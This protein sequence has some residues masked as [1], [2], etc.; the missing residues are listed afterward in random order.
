MVPTGSQSV[1]VSNLNEIISLLRSCRDRRQPVVT[2]DSPV[3]RTYNLSR[4][5]GALQ[6]DFSAISHCLIDPAKKLAVAGPGTKYSTI[7]QEAQSKGM[8]IDIE[9]IAC[10]DF[11][12]GD[13]AH[14]PLRLLS[15]INSGIDGILRNVKVIS[16][17]RMFQTGYDNFPANGGGYDLTKMYMSSG[18]SLGIPYEFA[19]PLR[20]IPDI[21]LKKVYSFKKPE[22]AIRAGISMHKTGYPRIV[23]LRSAG[24]ESMLSSGNALSNEDNLV[25]KLEGNQSIIDAAEKSLD[26][27]AKKSGGVAKDKSSDVPKFI[28][29][30]SISP[31]S[32]LIGI[33]ACD[34][35]E[36]STIINDLS[37]IARQANKQFQYCVSD[38]DPNA[39]I[40]V[41]M[42]Q[43][44]PSEETLGKIG[45]YLV[46]R[47]LP[48]RGNSSWN[49]V[50][51]DSRAPVRIELVRGIKRYLDSQM[52]LNPHTM[53]VY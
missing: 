22:D 39:S 40:L 16:P 31:S 24:F 20:P 2:V 42:L 19:M 13:W 26:E 36:L 38:L 10:I 23:K 17:D 27:I 8:I 49:P 5:E 25:V 47:R 1:K 53:G 41:P 37:K 15:A 35:L 21:L 11:T 45:S 50:L 12:M 44:P 51:G 14:E 28:D 32:W 30:T 6:I 46:D 3:L 7:V 9:P 52:I 4:I 18:L 33:C 29:P 43:G 34:S 48:L